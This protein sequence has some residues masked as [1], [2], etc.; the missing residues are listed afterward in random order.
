[1]DAAIVRTMKR[2]KAMVHKDLLGSFSEAISSCNNKSLKIAG[3][4]N[5]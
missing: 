2:R 5:Q 1:M 4:N 3:N